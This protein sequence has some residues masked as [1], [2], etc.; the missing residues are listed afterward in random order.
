V[1][2]GGGGGR[3][4]WTTER[5]PVWGKKQNQKNQKTREQVLVP[6]NFIEVSP[7]SSTGIQNSVLELTETCS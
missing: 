7:G 3:E 6:A 5:N 4:W 1:G 2:D